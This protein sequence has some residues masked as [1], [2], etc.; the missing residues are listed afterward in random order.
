MLASRFPTCSV[1]MLR[2]LRERGFPQ[3]IRVPQRICA[4]TYGFLNVMCPIISLGDVLSLLL[5][6]FAALSYID[7]HNNKKK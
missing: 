1:F 6:L 7:N 4:A 2:K 5:V 3:G